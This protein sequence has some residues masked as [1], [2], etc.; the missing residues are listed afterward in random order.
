MNKTL[1]PECFTPDSLVDRA[2]NLLFAWI[3]ETGPPTTLEGGWVGE[4]VEWTRRCREQVDTLRMPARIFRPLM[5]RLAT[6]V[7]ADDPY[8]SVAT[9][10]WEGPGQTCYFRL[11]F[12]NEPKM[13]FWLRLY[14]YGRSQDWSDGHSEAPVVLAEE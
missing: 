1:T 13:D 6:L 11:F 2:L 14:L 7:E 4:E 3:L 8:G 5:A 10:A 12:C 9:F